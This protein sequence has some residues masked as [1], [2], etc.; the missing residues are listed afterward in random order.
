MPQ[1]VEYIVHEAL[2]WRCIVH[3]VRHHPRHTELG[4]QWA[5]L[6]DQ[7]A[8][9]G[10]A[11]IPAFHREMLAEHVA[12]FTGGCVGIAGASFGQQLRY[13]ATGAAGECGHALHVTGN[14]RPRHTGGAALAVHARPGDQRGDVAIAVARFGEQHHMRASL[15]ARVADVGHAY[16]ELNA[17][18]A[19]DAER[20]AGGAKPDHAAQIIVVGNG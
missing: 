19:T 6:R 16:G 15:G 12:Q 17:Q 11:M 1:R 18:N 8:L 3:V 4:R 2:L 13:P 20:G 9:F 14:E 10:E 5:Q 7:R